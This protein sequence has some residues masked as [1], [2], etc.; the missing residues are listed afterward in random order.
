MYVLNYSRNRTFYL[1]GA[2]ERT[3]RCTI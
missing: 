2:C 1:F 3:G